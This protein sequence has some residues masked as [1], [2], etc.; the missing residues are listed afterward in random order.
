MGAAGRVLGRA[1][2]GGGFAVIGFVGASGEGMGGGAW[3]ARAGA[4]SMTTSIGGGG[5]GEMG[6]APGAAWGV[7]GERELA[8]S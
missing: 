5:G 6:V 4:S 8:L 1:G 7:G 3:V 2:V